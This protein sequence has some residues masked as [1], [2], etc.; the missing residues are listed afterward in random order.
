MESFQ[1]FGDRAVKKIVDG[2]VGVV[3]TDTIYGVVCNALNMQS[4]ERV[5]QVC[6]RD[7]DKP[8]I[9]TI[10]DFSDLELFGITLKD[11][12]KKTLDNVWPGEVSVI[13]ECANTEFYYLHRGLNSIA[14]RFPKEKRF[15]SF[16][17]KTGP[18][19]ATSAN[20]QG[21]AQANSVEEAVKYFG[22]SV[23]FY[24]DFGKLE[25]NPSTLIRI[26]NGKTRVLREGF[27]KIKE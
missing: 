24:V 14:F 9:V 27:V 17:K 22:N 7:A 19:V 23:D 4:V 3:P 15:L 6:K 12:A 26:S 13:L 10:G 1:E 16:L 2:G 20:P 8:L 11:K 25:A 21:K 18:L 5:Y